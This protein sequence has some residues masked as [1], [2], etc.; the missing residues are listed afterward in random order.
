MLNENKFFFFIKSG[1]FINNISFFCYADDD[2]LA[3]GFFSQLANFLIDFI[4]VLED[5]TTCQLPDKSGSS[6]CIRIQY[7]DSFT[8]IVRKFSGNPPASEREFILKH[9]CGGNVST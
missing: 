7:C 9:S 4:N 5:G 3:R 2:S 1:R 6:T 8:A